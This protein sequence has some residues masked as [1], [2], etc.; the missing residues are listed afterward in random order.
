MS[1]MRNIPAVEDIEAEGFYPDGLTEAAIDALLQD[2]D[3]ELA[4]DE[5]A[6]SAA[7]LYDFNDQRRASRA[8]R[9]AG[10]EALRTL[11]A[12]LPLARPFEIEAA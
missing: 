10:R 4:A 2:V 3:R 12:R 6:A 1:T 8:R 5:H 7:F 9:R 11:P